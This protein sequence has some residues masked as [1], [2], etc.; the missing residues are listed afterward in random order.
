MYCCDLFGCL[1]DVLAGYKTCLK[2][3]QGSQVLASL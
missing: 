3:P 2:K 1:F